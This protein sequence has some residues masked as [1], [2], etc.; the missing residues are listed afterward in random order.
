M[1]WGENEGWLVWPKLVLTIKRVKVHSEY[2]ISKI[3]GNCEILKSIYRG[4]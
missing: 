3:R 1:G 2:F 4:N